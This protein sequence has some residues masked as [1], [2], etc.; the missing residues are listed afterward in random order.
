[1]GVE[2][3]VVGILIAAGT[4]LVVFFSVWRWV[5][6]DPRPESCFFCGI[7]Y[8]CRVA[9]VGG[10]RAYGQFSMTSVIFMAAYCY[11]DSAQRNSRV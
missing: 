10:G 9:N 4:T 11:A 2:L 8:V 5:L 1:M 7:C 6:R 3:G